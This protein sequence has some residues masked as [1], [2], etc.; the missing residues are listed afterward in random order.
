LALVDAEI[1]FQDGVDLLLGRTGNRDVRAAA[2]RLAV[3]AER[4]AGAAELLANLTASPALGRSD[5]TRAFELMRHA[6]ALGSTRAQRQLALLSG[7][8]GRIDLAYWFTPPPRDVL[9]EAPR[10][11]FAKD[12]APAWACDWLIEHARDRLSPGVMYSGLT[13]SVGFDAN[14]RCSDY[15]FEI[16]NSDL[17]LLLV[18]ERVAALTRLPVEAMEPPRVF[19]YA[20]GEHI[21]P[22][23]DRLSDGP[24]GIGEVQAYK[25]DRIATFLLYLNDDYD[26]GELD[27]PKVGLSHKGKTGDALYFTHVDAAG[28]PDRLSLHAG[29]PI[30]RNEKWVLSQWIHDRPYAG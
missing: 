5:W 6:A 19:H 8:D 27:F 16:I 20:L 22:H 21:K 7:P 24:G 13:R 18:R 10:V 14:R 3:A 12:F 2:A 30:T 28:K 11:R 23:Y 29:L 17:V 1:A 15:Q 25:G 4:H 9:C 26:G